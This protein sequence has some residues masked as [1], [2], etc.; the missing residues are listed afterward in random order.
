MQSAELK[1]YG[2]G[3]GVTPAL[4]LVHGSRD[5]PLRSLTL[6]QL[7]AEQSLKYGDSREAIVTSWTGVRLTYGQ[8]H[9]RCKAVARSLVALGIQK[10][11][12][13]GI[14]SVNCERYVELFLAG[15][16]IGAMVVVLNNTYT[17]VECLNAV[18]HT[19]ILIT[20]SLFYLL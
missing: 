15:T 9:A 20:I 3:N 6:G 8:L 18:K 10:G 11:D 7:L 14:L 2:N 4:S 12:R 5:S 1:P 16:L 19:G 13:I 17:A